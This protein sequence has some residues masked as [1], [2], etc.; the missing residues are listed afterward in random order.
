MPSLAPPHPLPESFAFASEAA[1]LRPATPRPHPREDV[2]LHLLAIE[3][4]RY[5]PALALHLRDQGMARL[6]TELVEA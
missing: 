5:A 6:R 3:I 4:T 2:R 1:P